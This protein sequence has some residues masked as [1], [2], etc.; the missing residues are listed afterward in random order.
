MR[1]PASSRQSSQ[2]GFSLLEV[3]IA[4]SV[5]AIGMLG[6]AAVFSAGMQRLSSSPGDVIATQKVAEAVESV[7]SARDSHVLVWAQLRNVNG[8]SG[9]DGGI[10]LDGPQPLKLPGNDGL[11]NTADEAAQPVESM[12]FPGHDQT[13]GTAD[14]QTITLSGYTREIVIRDVPGELDVNGVCM[15]RSITV[16]VIYQA[17]TGSRTYSLTT[18]ISNYS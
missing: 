4:L 1:T 8:L 5:M 16:T 9:T 14:D 2:G 17:S 13:L 10:F 15:L 7:F 11:F 18:Y 3:V 6:A 12:V